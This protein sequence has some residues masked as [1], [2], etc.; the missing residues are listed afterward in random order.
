[1]RGL[2]GGLGLVGAIGTATHF[3]LVWG[4]ELTM[5]PKLEVAPPV[6]EWGGKELG[7]DAF[8]HAVYA[9]AT[10]AVFVLLDRQARR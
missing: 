7:I 1:V 2:L 9:V 5:L 10:G 4:S 8:H 3:G 6:K